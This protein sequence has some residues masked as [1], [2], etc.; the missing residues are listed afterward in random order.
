MFNIGWENNKKVGREIE[1]RK[2]TEKFYIYT[3]L[4]AVLWYTHLPDKRETT[5]YLMD[6]HC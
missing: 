2:Y 5:I 1:V 6:H 4:V 3:I